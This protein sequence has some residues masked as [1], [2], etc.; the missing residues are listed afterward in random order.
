MTGH[1]Q[2]V[3]EGTL[4]VHERQLLLTWARASVAAAL[5]AEPVPPRPD[6]SALVAPLGAF[7]SL[8]LKSSGDLRGC[9]GVLRSSEPLVETVGRMAVAAALHDARFAPVVAAELADLMLEV[10]VL[11]PLLEARPEDIEIGRHGI[12]LEMGASRAVLLPQVAVDQ[13]WDRETFLAKVCGKAGLPPLA[14]RERQ[15]RIYAFTATVFAE[16]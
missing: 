8:H 15:A 16:A 14:W 13:G 12:L 7:V 4:S 11:G 5:G 1:D 2:A 9:V 3:A 10:S 6:S